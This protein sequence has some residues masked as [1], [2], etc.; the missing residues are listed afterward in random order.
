MRRR[1]FLA[2]TAFGALAAA[3]TA[4]AHT[5]G[6]G[7]PPAAG[8]PATE[9]LGTV[10]LPD[11]AEAVVGADGARTYVATQDGFAVVDTSDP[12]DPSVL[13][14]VADI[15]AD[16]EAGPMA[17]VQDLSVEGDRL[18]VVG[19]AHPRSVLAGAALY[20]VSDP[21]A[22]A[23]VSFHQTDYPIHNAVL[24][25]GRA[26]LTGNGA[27][28]NPLVILEASAEPAELGRWSLFHED[29][30]WEAVPPTLRVLHDVRVRDDLA[31]LAHWD[32]G[33]W[34]VDVSAPEDPSTVARVRG[35]EPA[36]LSGYED[37]D[38]VVREATERPGNDH[39][40]TVGD[41]GT[42]LGIGIEAWD[43]DDDGEG[44]PG[45]IELWDV[46]EPTSPERLGA[47][48]PPATPDPTRA[49][50]WT[51][52]HNFELT[53]GHCYSAWYQGGVRVHDVSDP[54]APE[55]RYAWRDE[56]AATFWTARRATP[57]ESVVAP[58]VGIGSDVGP[59]APEAVDG[60]ATPT[61]GDGAG[62]PT[63]YVFPDPVPGP[64]ETP[65]DATTGDPPAGQGEDVDSA[66][67]PGFGALAALAAVSSF[68]LGL[69]RRRG[70]F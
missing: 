38:A 26:Y 15:R 18:L 53:A 19:P 13:A 59:D 64:T 52:A 10:D 67:G 39:F 34:I 32:A 48:D 51:T 70:E 44:A 66:E 50:V 33:T 17:N 61:P 63:L 24:V 54:R 49:G 45:G 37:R 36:Q 55:E 62:E 60:T 3:G 35:P 1:A 12:R 22:P 47:I 16:H 46:S 20:D 65:G 4:G 43:Y 31:Y 11:A 28:G 27:E 41:D 68:A 23:L 14:S 29:A 21:A 69:G 8:D 30:A 7:T 6:D 25:D 2:G 58:S 40:V 42:L 57:G 56:R 9:P 5:P